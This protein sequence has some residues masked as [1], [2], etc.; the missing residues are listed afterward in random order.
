MIVVAVRES[1]ERMWRAINGLSKEVQELVQGDAGTDGKQDTEPMP[2]NVNLVKDEPVPATESSI[3]PLPNSV[4][5]SPTHFT[6]LSGIPKARI[7]T[8]LLL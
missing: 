8:P 7:T 1:Q 3:A 5:I 6:C 4:T 2:M